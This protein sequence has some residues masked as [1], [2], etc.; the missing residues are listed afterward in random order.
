MPSALQL[1]LSFMITMGG[2]GFVLG[3][4]LPTTWL[5][6]TGS[7]ATTELHEVMVDA[8]AGLHEVVA[9]AIDSSHL[10]RWSSVVGSVVG[11]GGVY[12]SLSY[13]N[14]PCL[15]PSSFLCKNLSEL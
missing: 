8:V 11:G 14:L 15:F 7:F 2:S 9:V 1:A 10:P 5:L 3:P 12:P 6:A 4:L 13:S